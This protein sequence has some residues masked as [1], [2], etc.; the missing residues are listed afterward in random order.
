MTKI[1]KNLIRKLIIEE[2]SYIRESDD[3]YV[4]Y[5]APSGDGQTAV[6]LRGKLPP[7]YPPPPEEPKKDHYKFSL[8]G[9]A[10]NQ[11]FDSEYMMTP[12]EQIPYRE[13]APALKKI[14]MNYIEVVREKKPKAYHDQF[15]DRTLKHLDEMN[16]LMKIHP[17]AQEPREKVDKMFERIR[18]QLT[19]DKKRI[20]SGEV[21]Q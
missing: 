13:M 21:Q 3:R 1:N 7:R 20:E 2:L 9:S 17:D 6:Q 5:N 8:K 11:Y 16:E 18:N 10:L 15:L 4:D 14:Y 19:K 12:L